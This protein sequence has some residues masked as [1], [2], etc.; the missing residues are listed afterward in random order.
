VL[1][2]EQLHKHSLVL[3]HGQFLLEQH[4]LTILS[5]LV[6]VRVVVTHLVVAVLVDINLAQIFP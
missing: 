4:Q 1:L 5:L 2:P 3:H 6:G